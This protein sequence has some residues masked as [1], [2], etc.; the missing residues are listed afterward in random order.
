MPLTVLI[1]L[2]FVGIASMLF[3]L[4][5]MIFPKKTDVEER[6]DSLATTTEEFSV[7][8]KPPT[9]MQKILARLGAKVP[10]RLQDYGK[11]M[12]VLVA[13]GIKKE[14]LP[15]FMGSKIVLAVILPVL[16]NLLYGIPIEKDPT[17]QIIFTAILAI[18]GFLLPTYWLRYKLKKRQTRI[19]H[20]LPDVLD[21]MMVCVESGISMDASMIKVCEDPMFKESPLITEM[22]ITLQETRAGKPRADAL[23]DMGERPMESDLKSFAAMLV[24]TER[25]GTSLVQSMRVHSDSLRTIRRQRAEEA[26]A[27]IAIKLLFPLAFFIFP[28]LLIVILGPAYLRIMKM[29]G[30]I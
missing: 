16:Y 13:A 28:A 11:Y 14:R 30:E 21:L 2:V 22:T 23:R 19:F 15:V 10:L 6:L 7:F 5:Y 27:K 4:M 8:E 1:I 29:F 18:L 17:V 20:D 3:F 25:L 24:Q 26:A 12:R 9:G